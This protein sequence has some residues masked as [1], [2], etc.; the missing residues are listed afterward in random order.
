MDKNTIVPQGTKDFIKRN[1]GLILA[2]QFNKLF[3]DAWDELNLLEY[4]SVI[5][6]FNNIGVDV[7]Q[8]MHYIPQYFFAHS[9]IKIC[10]VKEN[11]MVI[12]E[13]AFAACT[14]LQTIKL[15]K[16]LKK[17]KNSAFSMCTHLSTINYNGTKE[18]WKKIKIDPAGNSVLF[19]S[20][21]IKCID[22]T[23]E[24]E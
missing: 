16:S 10:V 22:G 6:I 8:Y 18:D 15:P 13:N 19:N 24:I 12:K 21:E 9:N 1:S 23:I 5:S 14:K 2:R 11:I 17:I 7:L 20:L 3:E 4:S